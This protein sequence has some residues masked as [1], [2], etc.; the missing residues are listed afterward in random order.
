MNATLEGKFGNVK[1]RGQSLL[2]LRSKC[3]IRSHF[4]LMCLLWMAVPVCPMVA[5]LMTFHSTPDQTLFFRFLGSL[6]RFRLVEAGGVSE[7]DRRRR[8]ATRLLWGLGHFSEIV[9]HFENQTH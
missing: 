6:S 5:A 3:Q 9:R 1:L 2:L 4:A 7:G 8:H